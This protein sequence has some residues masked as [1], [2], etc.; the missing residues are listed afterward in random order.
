[1]NPQRA[2]ALWALLRSPS[3]DP[4]RERPALLVSV[5][6]AMLGLLVY[7][8]QREARCDAEYVRIVPHRRRPVIVRM[9]EAGE[10]LGD[11]PDPDSG[12]SG[13]EITIGEWTEIRREQFSPR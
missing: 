5:P 3:L 4:M 7:P 2:G 1:M 8:L 12:A 9:N 11:G 10:T 13:F 6:G